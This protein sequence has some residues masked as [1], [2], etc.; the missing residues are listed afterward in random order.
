MLG[1]SGGVGSDLAGRGVYWAAL[2]AAGPCFLCSC[3]LGVLQC[4]NLP[5]AAAA[6]AGGTHVGVLETGCVRVGEGWGRADG[7]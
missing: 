4:V 6:L 1:N 5:L 7:K 2:L 3:L